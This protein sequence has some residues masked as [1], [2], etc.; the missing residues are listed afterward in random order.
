MLP[1]DLSGLI[2]L[3]NELINEVLFSPIVLAIITVIVGLIAA[4]VIGKI[5]LYI[6]RKHKED[7]IAIKSAA[8]LIELFIFVASIIIA[9][10]F[11]QVSAA[12]VLLSNIFYFIPMVVILFLLLVL[13]YIV[14]T[15]IVGVMKSLFERF[16]SEEFL[17]EIGISKELIGIF[18]MLVKIFLFVIV[19]ILAFSSVGIS[20]TLL[21]N[22]LTGLVFGL[23]ILVM[24]IL[25]FSFKDFFTNFFASMFIERTLLKPGQQIRVGEK[26]GEII[27]VN[28]HGVMIRLPDGYNAIIPNKMILS[29]RIYLKRTRSDIS[30]L[31]EIRSRYVCQLPYYCG[32]AAAQMMLS[33]FGYDFTQEEIGKESLTKSPGGT[34]PNKLISAVKRITASGVAG[35]IIRYNQIY[36]LRDEVKSWIADGA[37][38]ILWYKKPVLFP[39]KSSQGGHFVLC[40]GIEGDELI[41]LDPSSQTA[42][43]YL[44]DYRLLEEAM[45]EYDKRRGYLVFAK[46]GTPAFWRMKEGLIY[47]DVSSYRTLSKSLERYLKKWVRRKSIIHELL[48]EHVVSFLS[49]KEG[50]GVKRIWKPDIKEEKKKLR[51]IKKVREEETE[52]KE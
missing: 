32:P 24:A 19:I 52:E 28:I 34:G 4:K 46:K 1:T 18:F 20:V 10:G 8:R 16:G 51:R 45:S 6:Y 27:G 3:S 33:F 25:F 22:F 9:L 11:L 43:V 30:K 21:S 50:R 47:A 36:N 40:V 39:E 49:G 31:E 5:L 7:S 12:R 15:L 13:G 42:G 17:Q 14:V 41:V 44:I 37:L 29:E 23:I 48:S 2:S 35:Q 38:I 26:V